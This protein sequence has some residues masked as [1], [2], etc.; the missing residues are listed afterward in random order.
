MSKFEIILNNK[1][2]E[3]LKS[4]NTIDNKKF[5]NKLKEFI[6][7]N[8]NE[9]NNNNNNKTDEEIKENINEL[10]KLYYEKKY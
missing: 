6:I 4:Y 7:N 1:M 8:Y 5:I 9:N 2:N 3:Y 10:I